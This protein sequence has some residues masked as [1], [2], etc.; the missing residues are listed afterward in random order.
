MNVFT[1]ESHKTKSSED[2]HHDKIVALEVRV[3]AIEGVD[4]Y[5]PIQLVKICLVKNI[6]VPKSFVCSSL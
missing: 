1:N 4:L 6:V 2:I 5:D 3:G